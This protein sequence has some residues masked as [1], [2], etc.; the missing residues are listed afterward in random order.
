[1]LVPCP[2]GHRVVGGGYNQT[3]DELRIVIPAPAATQWFVNATS[4]APYGTILTVHA[5]CLAS[6]HPNA[7]TASSLETTAA[8]RHPASLRHSQGE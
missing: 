2:A 3:S 6:D 4:E 1:M 5:I 7:I 8:K